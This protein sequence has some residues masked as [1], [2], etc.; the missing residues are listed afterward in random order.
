MSTKTPKGRSCYLFAHCRRIKIWLGQ[1]LVKA[2]AALKVLESL[3]LNA[4][5][6]LANCSQKTATQ[7]L[8]DVR[9]HAQAS[10][11]SGV[12]HM[13]STISEMAGE[14]KR[15]GETKINR[16]LNTVFSISK[17]FAQVADGV[18]ANLAEK[19]RDSKGGKKHESE[20]A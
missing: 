20:E 13:A 17:H 19:L 3:V 8:T 9:D 1:D 5:G 12:K 16:A 4:L 14:L 10:G 18:L 15:K 6:E 11:A 2:K 7:L